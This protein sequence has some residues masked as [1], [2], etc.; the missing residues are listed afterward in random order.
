M[1]TRY[2]FTLD[3]EEA[4]LFCGL[5][6]EGVERTLEMKATYIAKG[7]THEVD[8]CDRHIAYLEAL[9]NKIFSSGHR[10]KGARGA[11]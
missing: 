6:R 10:V 3:A 7:A 11:G 9:N 2:E 5:L 1:Q 8:W 4:E